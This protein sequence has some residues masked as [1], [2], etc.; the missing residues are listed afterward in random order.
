MKRKH[1]EGVQRSI[2]EYARHET[3]Q[4]REEVVYILRLGEGCFWVGRTDAIGPCV[5]EH[6]CGTAVAWTRLHRVLGVDFAA[7]GGTALETAKLVEL[8][9]RYGWD[10][11]RGGD[12]A[13]LD[14]L[15]PLW[16]KHEIKRYKSLLEGK[17][18]RDD[19]LRLAVGAPPRERPHEHTSPLLHGIRALGDA[20]TGEPA[21]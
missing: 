5:A 14:R 19:A 4:L 9:L 20:Q 2:C 11:V 17:R 15:C 1:A 6:M 16:L 8:A 12:W 13:D 18:L 21:T 3:T 7:L 10:K